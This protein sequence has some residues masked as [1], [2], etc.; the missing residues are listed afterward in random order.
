MAVSK[1]VGYRR[2]FFALCAKFGAD[3]LAVF[4]KLLDVV[5]VHRILC[6]VDLVQINSFSITVLASNIERTA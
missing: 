6:V 2:A 3:G 5:E 1:G 4:G